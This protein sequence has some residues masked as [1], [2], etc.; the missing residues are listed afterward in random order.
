MGGLRG[1]CNPDSP[2]EVRH[3]GD[4]ELQVIDN[5]SEARNDATAAGRGVLV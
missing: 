1:S 4:H 2:G 3:P 5:L